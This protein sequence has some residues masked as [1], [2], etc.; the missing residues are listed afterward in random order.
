MLRL[1]FAGV[2]LPPVGGDGVAGA[3]QPF[4]IMAELFQHFGGEKLRAI[5]GGLAEGLQ[6]TSGNE[7]RNLV[8]LE[9]EIPGSLA[10]VEA[11]GQNL[12]A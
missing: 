1:S 11:R 12:P 2:S 3:S 10:G 4:L 9:S 5:A 6:Q 8:R 7:D